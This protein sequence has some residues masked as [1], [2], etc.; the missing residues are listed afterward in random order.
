MTNILRKKITLGTGI[1]PSIQNAAWFWDNLISATEA[2]TLKGIE[3]TAGSSVSRRMTLTGEQATNGGDEGEVFF[4]VPVVTGAGLS[5]LGLSRGLAIRIAAKR[6]FQSMDSLEAASDLF[7]TLI[8]ENPAMLLKESVKAYSTGNR[9]A[10]ERGVGVDLSFI[11]VELSPSGRYLQVD[12]EIPLGGQTERVRLLFEF[13]TLREYVDAFVTRANG[14][15]RGDRMNGNSMLRS[16]IQKSDVRI[17]A[18][19]ERVDMSFGACSKL[20]VGQVLPLMRA[21]QNSI[22]IAVET[23]DGSTDVSEGRLGVWKK[24]RAV[25]LTAPVSKSFI[26][27]L[28]AF[29]VG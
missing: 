6:M 17:N 2:W 4:S 10:F 8:C 21:D 3:A 14:P 11:P 12:I 20:R 19:L 28:S 5:G 13:G 9:H 26:G 24:N 1:P 15:G 18:V 22:S 27:D 7:L 25:Q 29:A 23:L 16:S